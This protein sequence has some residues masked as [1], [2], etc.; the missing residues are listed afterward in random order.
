M[1]IPNNTQ[2]SD[3]AISA[4]DITKTYRL[5]DNPGDRVKEVFH[6]LRKQY[7]RKF[8]A[9][10]KVSLSIKKGE[11]VGIIGRNGSGKSTLLQIISGVIQPSSG[12]V[13]V[14]GRISAL[15]EL[16]AGFNPEFTGKE[17]V[18]LYGSILGLNGKE[19]N[20][21][22]PKIVE[23]ADI[24]QFIDQPVKVYS[25]GMYVRLAFAVAIN[26]NPEILIVDEALAVGDTLFQ[27]KCFD[28]FREFKEKGITIIFV[29]H[30][31]GMITSYCSHAY[32][33]EKGEI[34]SEGDPK[35]VVDDYNRMVVGCDK[36]PDEL[37][38]RKKGSHR[39][40]EEK[41]WEGLFDLNP[42]ENRYGK[43]GVQIIEAAIFSQEST[44]QQIL[45]KGKTYEFHM[46]VRFD[47][48]I[49]NP[50][51]AYTIKDIKGFDITGTNT[52]FKGIH[53]GR[54]DKGETTIVVF[55]H[56]M[57]LNAGSFL[58]SFGCAGFENG[59]YV[60]YERRYDYMTFEVISSIPGVGFLD[61]DSDIFFSETGD[62]TCLH[63]IAAH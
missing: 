51:F 19:M 52:F 38:P 41:Q 40:L 46:K 47:E 36:D 55:R 57:M 15:L 22:Y 61:L 12:N 63:E 17:N 5:Y 10:H 37:K 30:A 56:K 26:V 21:L 9:L 4:C 11:T 33:I 54:F 60:V 48:T 32:L 43:G 20:A 7:H 25:S 34:Y 62:G 1:P 59:E 49:D 14:Y 6:P 24:G 2:A 44:P 31:L 18:Y 28:K 8:D 39:A 27:A 13:S 35:R 50:I 42:K 45:E 58:L 29:T 53:T 16:G 23:F 3:V